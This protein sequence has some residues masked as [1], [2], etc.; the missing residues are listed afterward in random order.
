MRVCGIAIVLLAGACQQQAKPP[1]KP[2]EIT[3]D[4]AQVS[5]AAALRAHGERLTHVLGCTGCHGADLQGKDMADKPG[6]G[7]MYSPNV[8]LVAAGYGDADFERLFRQGVPKDGREFW[9]MQVES[10]Q[11]LSDADLAALIAYLRSLKPRGNAWPAFKMNRVEQKDV[12]QGVIGDAKAQIAKYRAR[13]PVD[14]GPRYVWGRYMAK[15]TCT[16]CH[17]NALQ[18]WPNFTPNLDIAGAYSKP[19]LRRLLATGKGK[20]GKDVGAMS[21]IARAYFS[22]LTPREREAIVDYVLARAN[23]TSR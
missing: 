8:T 4:G 17:N 15:S 7:A 10:Y 18:G 14:L 19:E 22:H 11:F 13:P 1:A 3:F 21:G 12:D 9:F 20:T 16:G 2:V 6:D 5:D 23:R